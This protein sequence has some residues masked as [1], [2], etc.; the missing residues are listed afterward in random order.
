MYRPD[1]HDAR[2][3]A[4]SV[5]HEAGTVEC[6]ACRVDDEPG[7]RYCRVCVVG[8]IGVFLRGDDGPI[9]RPRR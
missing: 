1:S 5:D 9:G 3:E 4:R 6:P 2:D 7:Y 8:G